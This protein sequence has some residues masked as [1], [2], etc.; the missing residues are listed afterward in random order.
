MT[1]YREVLPDASLAESV[2]CFWT[3][4]FTPHADPHRVLLM[5]ARI[6]SIREAAAR[7]SFNLSVP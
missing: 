1:E 4:K 5:A 6:L 2:E 7:A 3:A